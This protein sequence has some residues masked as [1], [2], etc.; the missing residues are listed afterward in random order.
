M[1]AQLNVPIFNGF[2]NK[3]KVKSSQIQKQQSEIRLANAK[4]QLKAEVKHVVADLLETSSRIQTRTG[5]RTAQL[6]YDI[7]QYRY[8]RGVASRLE[9]TDAELALTTAQSNYLKR[10]MITYQHALH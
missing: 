1:G 6:S 3:A 2:L 10:C 7:T 8:G 4:E 5:V 9:L